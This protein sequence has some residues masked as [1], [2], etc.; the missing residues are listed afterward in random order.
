MAFIHENY[1]RKISLEDIA[2]SVYVSKNTALQIF[3]EHIRLSPVA[4]LIGYRL[5]RAA[6]LLTGGMAVSRI[7][8]KCGFESGTYFSRKFKEMYGCSPS[9]YRARTAGAKGETHE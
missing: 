4:Y 7:A 5:E 2:A 8:E 6:K 1:A 9:E 3:R